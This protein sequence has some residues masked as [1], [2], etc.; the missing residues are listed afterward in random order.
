[1]TAAVQL[2]KVGLRAVHEVGPVGKRPHERDRE[3]VPDGLA[4]AR[5]VLDVVR[6]VRQRVALG[7]AAF[8]RDGLVAAGERDRLKREEVDLLRVVQRELDDPADLLVVDPV[9][10]RDDRHDIHTGRVQVLDRPQ[11]HVEQ[12][13]DLPVRVGGVSDPVELEVRVS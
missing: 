2:A 5:L 1:M 8:R 12:V 7:V 10:D 11:L 13:T 9:Q 3:P 4:N 6:Q